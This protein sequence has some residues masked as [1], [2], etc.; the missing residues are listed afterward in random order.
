MTLGKPVKVLIG[1]L[2]A[3]PFLYVLLF[4]GIMMWML[5]VVP[6]G[7]GPDRHSGGAPVAFMVLFG[8][9]LATMLLMVALIAFYVVYLFKT[10]RVAQDKKALWAVVL[11]LGNMLAMPVFFYLYIWPS[12][13]PR[14]SVGQ[15]GRGTTSA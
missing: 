6:A 11:F 14:S 4:M 15:A 8:A 7:G 1:A 10:N 12:S 5:W 9:H 2:T 3:W 13:W